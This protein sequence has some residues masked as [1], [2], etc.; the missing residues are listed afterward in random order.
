MSTLYVS[1]LNL[2]Y[3]QYVGLMK[4]FLAIVIPAIFC[5]ICFTTD[6][7]AQI[8]EQIETVFLIQSKLS[9]SGTSNVT[10][11][12]CIYEGEMEKD[13][14]SHSIFLSDSTFIVKGD[15]LALEI[16]AFDC[17]RRGINRDFRKTL[18]STLYPNIN[19]NLLNFKATDQLLKNMQVLISIA[20]DSKKYLLDF[21]V[22]S[23]SKDI[24][25]ISGQQKLNMT[26]FELDPPKA[27]FGL[28]QV[29]DEIIITFDIFMKHL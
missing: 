13:T 16:D 22:F 3:N 1:E 11:F 9:I 26:D 4:T 23:P 24:F 8:P 5:T 10:D 25:R 7:T 21:E 14:L 17:G 27:L 28:I 2:K 15:T 6:T 20:G 12:E 29:R 18:K 19:I